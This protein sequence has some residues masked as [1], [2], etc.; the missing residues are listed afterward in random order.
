MYRHSRSDSLIDGVITGIDRVLRLL[1]Q[2][3][4]P[5]RHNPSQDIEEAELTASEKKHISGL[6]RVNHAGEVCAQALYYGHAFATMNESLKTHFL[7]AAREEADHLGWCSQRIHELGSHTSYLNPCWFTGSFLIGATAA[8]IGDEW[9][10]GF[11]AETESQVAEHLASHMDKLPE[12]DLKTR[13]LL[14]QMQQD[15]LQH[16]EEAIQKGARS[17]PAPIQ[18]AMRYSAKIMTKTAYYI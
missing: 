8:F 7:Q 10:L 2:N 6:M 1:S 16:K 14:R 12:H 11:V 18:V 5:K 15:E 17:F 4:A 3:E 13:A 9:G